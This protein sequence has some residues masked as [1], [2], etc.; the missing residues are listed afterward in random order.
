MS[1]PSVPKVILFDIDGTLLTAHGAGKRALTLA[2]RYVFGR[3]N[4]FDGIDFRGMTDALIIE[5]ALAR[6]QAAVRP[7]ELEAVYSAYLRELERE[8]C[9]SHSARAMPGAAELLD[10]LR[11]QTGPIAI[12]LG[13][14]NIEPAAYMK[15]R[16][17]NLDAY[18][19]FG[20]FGSDHRIRSEI[21]RV[22]AQRGAA[23]LG[24]AFDECQVIVIGDTFHDVDAA[25]AIGARAI[26]VGT[27]GVT[28]D[29]L[30]QHGASYAFDG[31]DNPL[32][33]TALL[34]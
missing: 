27:S 6:G 20:G 19:S 26:G 2:L 33:R 22:G 32:V 12:G 28:A 30:L 10:W 13:T 31:L 34:A 5:Q 15:L 23:S 9:A 24:C 3:E 8:L 14:G 18:F 1:K 25:L 17:V 16:S 29:A 21:I 4:A 7:S 11:R